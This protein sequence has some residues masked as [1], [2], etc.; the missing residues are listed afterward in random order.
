MSKSFRLAKLAGDVP[1]HLAGRAYGVAVQVM[2][3]EPKAR[4]VRYVTGWIGWDSL[5]L[6]QRRD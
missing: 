3:R 2:W 4:V 6:A 5:N 1:K